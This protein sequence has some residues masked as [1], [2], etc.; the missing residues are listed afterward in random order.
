MGCNGRD[1]NVA[2]KWQSS[3]SF[4]FK[5]VSEN[6]I[7]K[8]PIDSFTE[9]IAYSLMHDLNAKQKFIHLIIGLDRSQ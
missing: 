3:H 2:M 5:I 8:I 6:A 9:P 7:K 1:S 4:T